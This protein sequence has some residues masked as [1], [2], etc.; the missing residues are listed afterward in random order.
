MS[1]TCKCGLDHED[2]EKQCLTCGDI[3]SFALVLTGSEKSRKFTASEKPTAVGRNVYLSLAGDEARF[4]SPSQYQVFQGSDTEWYLQALPRTVNLTAVNGTVCAPETPVMLQ[5]G[6]TVA[7][8]TKNDLS[9][10]HAELKVS[11]IK[12]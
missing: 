5:T 8:V 6:D 2:S 7:I 1:W 3:V 11:F 4:V 10:P 12:S 9:A